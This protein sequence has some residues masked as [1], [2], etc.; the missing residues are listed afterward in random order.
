M[1]KVCS[2]QKNHSSCFTCSR[3]LRPGQTDRPTGSLLL[4]FGGFGRRNPLN[5]HESIESMSCLQPSEGEVPHAAF[6]CKTLTTVGA[7]MPE[8]EASTVLFGN[9]VQKSCVFEVQHREWHCFVDSCDNIAGS[10]YGMVSCSKMP[11]N[12]RNFPN[13]HISAWLLVGFWDLARSAFPATVLY[14]FR[15]RWIYRDWMAGLELIMISCLSF[16]RHLRCQQNPN[17]QTRSQG[18]FCEAAKPNNC[19]V[20]EMETFDSHKAE[21]ILLKSGD[22]DCRC[23]IF[24]LFFGI[25]LLYLVCWWQVKL[26]RK[27]LACLADEDWLPSFPSSI[28]RWGDCIRKRPVHC[29]RRH[30]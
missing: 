14:R 28:W 23:L 9:S 16:W 10:S 20:Q 19:L 1:V 4:K 5:P 26:Q 15:L 3:L 2:F 12:S 29:V 21:V 30:L 18:S 8:S 13:S 24:D 7:L 6:L 22:I 11:L 17:Y 27:I 25:E